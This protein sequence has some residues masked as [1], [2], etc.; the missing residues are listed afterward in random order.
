MSP[1]AP[2]Q[3]GIKRCSAGA[4]NAVGHLPGGADVSSKRFHMRAGCH[5][6]DGAQRRIASRNCHARAGDAGRVGRH[7]SGC[8]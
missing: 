6:Y 2:V 1:S 7:D 8:R 3:A 4:L 5:Q